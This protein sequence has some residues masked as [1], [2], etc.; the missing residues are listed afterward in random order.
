MGIADR[1]YQQSSGS[2][3]FDAGSG[4]PSWRQWRM[5]SVT[6]WLIVICT[7]VFVVDSFLPRVE[8]GMARRA[9]DGVPANVNLGRATPGETAVVSAFPG[10]PARAQRPLMLEIDGTPTVVGYQLVRTMPPLEALLHFSTQRGFFHLE[11]WRL[12]GFQ[13][14]HSHGMLAH[15]LM[16]MVGLFFFGPIVEQHLG[17]KRFLAFYLLCGICGGLLFTLLNVAAHAL[18]RVG[19]ENTGIPFLLFLDS[20][21]PLIGASAGVFGV[22]IGGARLAPRTTVNF[23]FLI[24][25]PLGVLAWGMVITEVVL[26]ATG[27][28]GND[29]GHAAHLGGAFA[30]WYF[31]RNDHHLRDFFD[32]LGRFD[33]TSRH[34][35]K[36]KSGRREGAGNFGFGETAAVPAGRAARPKLIGRINADPSPEAVDAILVK[37]KANGIHSLTAKEQKILERDRQAKLRDSP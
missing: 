22:M 20:T 7:A 34:Y 16:N 9:L 11:L 8:V 28:S 19:V 14:L 2:N 6:T 31:I 4:T 29:G 3:L 21:T 33:P 15:L 12:L 32:V 24:P 26:L 10:S 30:G 37:V 5:W 1:D 35:R 25:M 23:M 18:F 36:E 27:A 17:G 13:F